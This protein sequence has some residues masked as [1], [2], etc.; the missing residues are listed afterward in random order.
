MNVNS[1][2]S[3][4]VLGGMRAVVLPLL[5]AATLAVTQTASA[6]AYTF[7]DLGT[8]GGTNSAAHAI[9]N[10]GHVVGDSLT[11][12]NTSVHATLWHGTSAIDLGTLGGTY[13]SASGINVLG[14]IVGTSTTNGDQFSRPTLWN[15]NVARALPINADY[16]NAVGINTIGQITGNAQA[17]ERV[18][19]W[20]GDSVTS[21]VA[22]AGGGPVS[23]IND[24]GLFVIQDRAPYRPFPPLGWLFKADS[25]GTVSEIGLIIDGVPYDINDSGFVVGSYSLY[26]LTGQDSFDGS[27]AAIWDPNTISSEGRPSIVGEIGS[28]LVAVNNSG[29]AVGTVE[30]DTYLGRRAIFSQGIGLGTTDLTSL[31]DSST[32]AAG[33]VLLEA[34]DI[35]DDGWI[36]GTARNTVTEVEHGFLL[37]PVPEPTRLALTAWGFGI[38]C[39]FAAFRRKRRVDHHFSVAIRPAM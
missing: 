29:Q 11:A 18:R 22:G 39:W 10:L 1:S 15:N 21:I 37:S 38:L 16:A 30:G 32:V 25:S 9:N 24:A 35:N 12:G 23:G 27:F 6:T 28:R 26:N 13:S 14:Q 7:T 2:R 4:F 33:W 8:L 3:I 20:S 19:F 5:V 31:L 36:V 17:N 34:R